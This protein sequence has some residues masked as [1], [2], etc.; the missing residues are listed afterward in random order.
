M[1]WWQGQTLVRTHTDRDVRMLVAKSSVGAHHV[2]LDLHGANLEMANL[3]HV[4]LQGANL[5]GAN[6][7]GAMLWG[8]QLNGACLD[9]ADLTCSNLTFASLHD[10]SLRGTLLVEADLDE[11]I[12]DRSL[13]EATTAG[14]GMQTVTIVL[15]ATAAQR[16]ETEGG[17]PRR[18]IPPE[19]KKAQEAA[20]LKAHLKSVPPA[21]RQRGVAGFSHKTQ[22]LKDAKTRVLSDADIQELLR[23]S[24]KEGKPLNLRGC[25]LSGANLRN[26]SLDGACLAGANLEGSDITHASFVD[27]DLTD[28]WGLPPSHQDR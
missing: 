13:S 12:V 26:A 3:P 14:A 10:C 28:V 5:A 15:S 22:S 6:L 4:D 25:N 2:P 21:L 1:G 18:E 7:R 17:I 23:W 27:T 8:T 19:V 24:A 11:T 9:G 20:I 16:V